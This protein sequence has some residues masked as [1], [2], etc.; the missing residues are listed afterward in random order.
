MRSWLIPI[1]AIVLFT[2]SLSSARADGDPIRGKVAFAQCS[3]CHATTLQDKLGPHLSGVFGRTAGAVPGFH[4][5]KAMGS[6]SI[7]W[8]E[9]ALDAF[10][11]APAKMLPGTSMPIALR[12]AQ[13]RADII[14][15][16]KSLTHP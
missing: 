9:Q 15:Y 10:L 4:Y 16:L 8:N 2:L 13:D 6:S 14:A 5:S 3:G 12:S 7:V 11:A 1:I